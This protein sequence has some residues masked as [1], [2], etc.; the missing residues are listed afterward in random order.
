MH[1]VPDNTKFGWQ[2]RQVEAVLLQVRQL[3]E[4]G[5]QITG[6]KSTLVASEELDGPEVGR[7]ADCWETKPRAQVRHSPEGLQV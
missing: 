6:W 2:L 3:F 4:Q 1:L 5:R 7:E